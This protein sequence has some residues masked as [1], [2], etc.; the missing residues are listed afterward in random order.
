MLQFLRF[1]HPQNWVFHCDVNIEFNTLHMN[2]MFKGPCIV[3]YVAIIIQQNTT[4]Y[5]LFISANWFQVASPPI[6]RSSYHRIYSNGL[7][8]VD[9]VIWAPNDGLSY[10]S[11]YVEQ[12]ADI[13][14]LYIVASCWIIIDTLICVFVL[15]CHRRTDWPGSFD[16]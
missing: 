9:T 13:N 12:F 14:K 1:L 4:I 15:N 5:S 2:I 11:K 8:T 16:I 3:E 6:I 10:H 7:N